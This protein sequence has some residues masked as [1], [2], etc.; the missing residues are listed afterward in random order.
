[1]STTIPSQPGDR[2]RA[3][4]ENCNGI[5]E[6]VIER[7]DVPLDDGSGTAQNALAAIC[8]DCGDIVA[9]PAQN[10]NIVPTP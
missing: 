7:R 3:I 2:S 9:M 6:T 8:T 10:L 1:M 4:C 5:Q